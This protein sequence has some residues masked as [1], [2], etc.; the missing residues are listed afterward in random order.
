MGQI[1]TRKPDPAVT[2]GH[3]KMDSADFVRSYEESRQTGQK[4]G[5]KASIAF[6]PDDWLRRRDARRRKRRI[7]L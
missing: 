1:M 2:G 3:L 7:P 6:D 5:T 4:T